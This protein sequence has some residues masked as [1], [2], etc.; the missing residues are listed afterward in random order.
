MT[1][2]M[3]DSVF[4]RQFTEEQH[5]SVP[6]VDSRQPLLG[7]LLSADNSVLDR[8]LPPSYSFYPLPLDREASTQLNANVSGRLI[9]RSRSAD[10]NYELSSRRHLG[11]SPDRILSI[12]AGVVSQVS[13][14]PSRLFSAVGVDRPRIPPSYFDV[15]SPSLVVS[16]LRGVPTGIDML[17]RVRVGKSFLQCSLLVE[18]YRI[19]A[20]RPVNKVCS[21]NS[22]CFF[23]RSVFFSSSL[24]LFF[25]FGRMAR[26]L[27]TERK[28]FFL[29]S[30]V[31]FLRNLFLTLPFFSFGF[32]LGSTCRG[33]NNIDSDG[34]YVLREVVEFPPAYIEELEEVLPPSYS[35]VE[36]SLPD[37]KISFISLI[38]D[39]EYIDLVLKV[40]YG[41][42]EYRYLISIADIYPRREKCVYLPRCMG[43]DYFRGYFS[44]MSLVFLSGMLMV[45]GRLY[46][47]HFFSPSLALLLLGGV[48]GYN[49]QSRDI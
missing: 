9:R 8:D 25:L 17:A 23:V 14:V 44:L 47:P 27:H 24:L 40:I 21:L 1:N 34:H 26:F 43:R 29:L 19:I 46:A 2:F 16:S 11:G 38:T 37:I 48:S 4:S 5:R 20:R 3:S 7:S 36:A 31:S 41:A 10:N 49:R 32:L 15:I 33:N 45:P 18:C 13:S 42:N 28:G 39:R 35:G 6:E 22:V 30:Q 12:E